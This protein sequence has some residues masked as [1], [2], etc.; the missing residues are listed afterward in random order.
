MVGRDASLADTAFING[1]R[2]GGDLLGA[3]GN[4]PTLSDPWHADAYSPLCGTPSSAC[5]S[6]RRSAKA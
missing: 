1:L 2:Y 4:F 6:S 5:G 3:F